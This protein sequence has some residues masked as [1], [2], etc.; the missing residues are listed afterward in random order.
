MMVPM[1]QMMTRRACFKLLQSPWEEDFVSLV[2]AAKESFIISSP[3]IGREACQIVAAQGVAK[4]S[5]KKLKLTVLTDL[6]RRNLLSGSTDAGAIHELV[7]GFPSSEVLFLPSV[8]AKV[9]IADDHAAI[10]TS[11]NMTAAGFSRNYEY[12]M[13]VDDHLLVREI[14]AHIEAYAAL[15]TK[16]E[17]SKLKLLSDISLDLQEMHREAEK[18]VNSRL[19]REFERRL[20]A[21][22]DEVLRTRTAG[23]APNAIFAEAILYNLKRS[24]MSTRELHQSIQ[25]IH[26]DL[27]DD[28][29]DRVIDGIHFGKK[30]KHA[31]R[32]AQQHL[33]EE[34]LIQLTDGA[35]HLSQE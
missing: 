32:S 20:L 18:T 14:R 5:A 13:R 6:S 35:W 33:K 22:D 16:I 9:Y 29:V 34:G 30:W 11:G 12:G 19:R 10:I 25:R 4:Q 1:D 27:C 7:S 28:R 23:R 3:Y 31:V 15:G 17:L 8:H 26:P 21:F 2:R 24:A